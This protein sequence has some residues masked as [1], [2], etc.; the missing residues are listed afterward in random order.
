MTN[1]NE[2]IHELA[3]PAIPAAL[4]NFPDSQINL[5][6]LSALAAPLQLLIQKWPGSDNPLN[7][8]V[9]L[10]LLLNG[11]RVA[12]FNFVTP[13]DPALFP[14]AAHIPEH[15]LQKEG[16]HQVSYIVN[17][18]GNPETSESTPFTIDVTAPNY[19]SSGE[20]VQFPQEVISDGITQKYLDE[21]G[22]EVLVTIPRYLQQ[23]A[24]DSIEFHYGS[25]TNSP[26]II[27]TV[28]DSSS[29]TV[30]KLSGEIIRAYGSGDK[31]AFYRLVDRAGNKGPFSAYESIKVNLS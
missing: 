30:I 1:L 21:H 6:P 22:D 9:I 5:L 28:H 19:G 27:T 4:I 8:P 11:E 7:V 15:Y 24:C 23:Q 3:P 16:V 20:I 14:F 10:I 17:T 12:N 2:K 29:P 13:I 26:I 31:L 18:A 25:L